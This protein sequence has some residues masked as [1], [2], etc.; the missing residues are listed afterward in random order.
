VH[1]YLTDRRRG[2]ASL[3]RRDERR[4]EKVGR[5]TSLGK[6]FTCVGSNGQSTFTGKC[7]LQRKVP[8]VFQKDFPWFCL[9][10]CMVTFLQ[11][12][13]HPSAD[14]GMTKECT[15]LPHLSRI[16]YLT[17]HAH[18][19]PHAPQSP[20]DLLT[21]HFVFKTP[22]PHFLHTPQAN[23]SVSPSSERICRG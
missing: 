22:C 6:C 10:F 12:T 8:L 2:Q 11:L 4:A 17:S 5:K 19:S 18:L 16:L 1:L 3:R 23:C 14:L 9:S 13:L 15:S 20:G 21:P 7:N